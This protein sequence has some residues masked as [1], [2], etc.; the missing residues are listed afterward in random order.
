MIP[1]KGQECWGI[2]WLTPSLSLF[3]AAWGKLT[4]PFLLDPSEPRQTSVPEV[5]TKGSGQGTNSVTCPMPFAWDSPSLH[6]FSENNYRV[7]H[8]PFKGHLFWM[9]CMA[10][11]LRE[12]TVADPDQC[13]PGA[14]SFCPLLILCNFSCGFP[15]R[16]GGDS[17]GWDAA[18]ASHMSAP[19]NLEHFSR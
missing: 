12:G 1:A 6:L 19:Q 11:P 14:C 3:G 10:P 4:P 7:P 5:R 2:Y 18:V 15:P 13:G 17:P 16:A 8:F 9:I